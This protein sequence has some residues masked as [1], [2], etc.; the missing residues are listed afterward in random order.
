M[1]SGSCKCP[2]PSSCSS[3]VTVPANKWFMYNVDQYALSRKKPY[4]SSLA[5]AAGLSSNKG[6]AHTREKKRN[7]R[8][9]AALEL[10]GTSRS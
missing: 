9:I 1:Q 2:A 5:A 3:G 7:R 10:H 6:I 8:M 4:Q